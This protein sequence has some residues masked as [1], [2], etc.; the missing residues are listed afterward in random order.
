MCTC[1]EPLCQPFTDMSVIRFKPICAVVTSLADDVDVGTL[2]PHLETFDGRQPRLS[3]RQL[4]TEFAGR[5]KNSVA[6]RAD[7]RVRVCR[8]VEL[9][10]GRREMDSRAGRL[11]AV[12]DGP[13]RQHAH[14]PLPSAIDDANDSIRRRRTLQATPAA[15]GR[16]GCRYTQSTRRQAT[17]ADGMHRAERTSAC[18]APLR[19]RAARRDSRTD[20]P[21]PEWMS[22][23]IAFHRSTRPAAHD[24]A[25]A[26]QPPPAHRLFRRRPPAPARCCQTRAAHRDSRRATAACRRASRPE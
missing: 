18:T 15:A 23:R 8:R 14:R 22:R 16:R 3:D 24:T 11:P 26:R 4:D 20:R 10:V 17:S 19:R 7:A 6:G 1:V 2:R 9:A 13:H 21:L 12:I 5:M 25:S